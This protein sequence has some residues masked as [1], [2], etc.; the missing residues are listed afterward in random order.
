MANRELP[1]S[2]TGSRPQGLKL[3]A[4]LTE[5]QVRPER[6][7]SPPQLPQSLSPE[8]PLA[9]LGPIHR[10]A[11]RLGALP[12][13]HL[14]PATLQAITGSVTSGLYRR[15]D[16]TLMEIIRLLMML[17]ALARSGLK[18]S[19]KPRLPRDSSLAMR[20]RGPLRLRVGL[21]KPRVLQ[22]SGSH[23]FKLPVNSEWKAGSGCQC[24]E[25]S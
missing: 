16:P 7:R 22:A 5:L 18:I 11:A 15:V 23:H 17:V 24:H 12:S 21:P 19:R 4:L 9:P 10:V 20:H 13:R 2:G 8:S 14:P 1:L 3:K 25:R 6:S